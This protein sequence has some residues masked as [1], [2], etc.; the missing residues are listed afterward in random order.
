MIVLKLP[1]P[2]SVNAMYK[3]K[4]NGRAK[5]LRY[6]TW[7]RAAGWEI[8]AQKQEPI[9][10]HYTLSVVLNE[11]DNRRRDIDNFVKCVSDL[12]VEHAL[13]E[14]DC[15]CVSISID[16]FKASKASCDVIVQESNGIP[17]RNAA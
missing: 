17:E 9:K 15:M 10:G 3:N 6:M 4:L 1:F 16:R 12:L 11:A 13:V 5:S 8:K 7:A 2:I 14:D